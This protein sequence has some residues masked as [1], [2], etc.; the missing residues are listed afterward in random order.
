[1][2]SAVDSDGRS[3]SRIAIPP[4]TSATATSVAAM[5]SGRL[6][7]YTDRRSRLRGG[8][9]RRER[10]GEPWPTVPD[11]PR[12]LAR[13]G[14]VGMALVALVLAH[15]LV[16]LVA[17][18]TAY[19]DALQ[20]TGHDAGW[21]IA[22]VV[23][24]GLAVGLLLAAALP[25]RPPLGGGPLARRARVDPPARPGDRHRRLRRP[26]AEAGGRDEPRRSSS[27]RTSNAGRSGNRCRALASSARAAIR[28]PCRSSSSSRSRSRSSAPS[29]LRGSRR[30]RPGS[31]PP[32]DAPGRGRATH[33]AAR[34]PSLIAS[35]DP[36]TA[37]SRP[38]APR[39][40]RSE[41][42]ERPR[43]GASRADVLPTGRGPPGRRSR[44]RSCSGDRTA[45]K[46]EDPIHVHPSAAPCRHA[47]RRRRARPLHG[48][49][50]RGPLD[51]ARRTVHARD[52]LA[53]R[54]DLHAAKST[55]SR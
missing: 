44:A 40:S 22:V 2:P 17:Y 51:P 41:P 54:A 49:A 47:H 23:I 16:Y 14:S 36:S 29:S 27:R 38:V 15:N 9:P 18:G 7:R 48:R 13:L 5:T 12:W 24:L 39:R 1:M 43:P 50:G 52:R 20:Q 19:E 53:P 46:S 3:V 21:T 6:T 55:P 42:A 45:S 35:P 26:V 11:M 28:T 37:V 30:S 4:R 32:G 33:D 10:S 31:P 25:D 8:G 34:S